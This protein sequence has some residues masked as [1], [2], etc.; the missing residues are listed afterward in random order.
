M[1][2][3]TRHGKHYNRDIVASKQDRRGSNPDLAVILAID[4]G[5]PVS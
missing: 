2:P 1:T 5:V 3:E 4:H